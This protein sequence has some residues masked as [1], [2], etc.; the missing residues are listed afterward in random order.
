MGQVS[1]SSTVMINAE[2][3]AVLTAV[4]DYQTVRPKILSSRYSGYQ[5]PECAG[6]TRVVSP[7]FVA[8]AHAAGLG[9]QVWTVDT[10]ADAERLLV[11]GV[12][13]LITDCPD[14]IVP[15]VCERRAAPT[16][17]KR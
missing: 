4:A 12:D 17:R 13:A 3:D 2:P 14:I 15:F 9:V 16:D 1:A 11:W 5:V 10:E 6:R 8:D 7:R